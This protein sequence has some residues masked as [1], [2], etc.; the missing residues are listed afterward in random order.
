MCSWTFLVL[1]CS[2]SFLWTENKCESS[3]F[4]YFQQDLRE[5]YLSFCSNK[6]E[7]PATA[8][9]TKALEDDDLQVNIQRMDFKLLAANSVVRTSYQT[10]K[11]SDIAEVW[12]LLR[13]SL[14]KWAFYVRYLRKQCRLHSFTWLNIW[15]LE[16]LEEITSYFALA[17]NFTSGI[18]KHVLGEERIV[19][20]QSCSMLCRFNNV[21][22]KQKKETQGP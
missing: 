20:T 6:S 14:K 11:Y 1:I 8:V 9:L 19:K 10:F 5:H 4:L 18:Y 22:L 13:S 2:H 17:E 15:Y 3:H 12:G 16:M 7:T 21:M